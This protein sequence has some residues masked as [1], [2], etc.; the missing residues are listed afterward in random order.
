MFGHSVCGLQRIFNPI[1]NSTEVYGAIPI[2]GDY[3]L[4]TGG[5]LDPKVTRLKTSDSPSDRQ[6]EGV[7]L[8]LHGPKYP[9]N[10]KSGKKQ[11]AIIDFVC[12]RK[13]QDRRRDEDGEDGGDK[14]GEGDEDSNPK[15]DGRETDDEDGGTLKFLSYDDVQDVQVLSLEWTTKHACEGSS[16]GGSSASSGHWGFFTWFIIM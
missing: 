6:K 10:S 1:E 8:L 12:D 7:R 13:E 11:Q 14:K 15:D 9:P 16:S 3:G 4:S 5:A 2:A